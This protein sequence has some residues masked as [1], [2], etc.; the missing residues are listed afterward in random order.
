VQAFEEG[1]AC[2]LQFLFEAHGAIAISAGPRLGAIFVAAFAAVVRILHLDQLKIVFPVRTLF[3]KRRRTV[4]DF[5]PAHRLIGTHSRVVHVAQVFALR[6]RACAKRA[7]PN[8]FRQR[9]LTAVF[10]PRSH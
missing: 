6:N 4:T 10:Q 3:L 1:F 8:R 7:A 5:H 2:V 9:L